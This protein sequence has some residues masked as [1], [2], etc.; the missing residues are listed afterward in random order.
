[1]G[2]RGL[3]NNR[4]ARKGPASGAPTSAVER[5]SVEIDYFSESSLA[6]G[7]P[8]AMFSFSK[9]SS[10]T[11]CP[12]LVLRTYFGR[13]EGKV[14][15]ALER[16]KKLRGARFWRLAHV[17]GLDVEQRSL[18]N[19]REAVGEDGSPASASADTS[20]RL[21]QPARSRSQC[22]G[23]DLLCA[24]YGLSVERPRRDRDLL[25]RLGIQAF[26]RMARRRGVS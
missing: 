17:H 22:H 12:G 3:A 19:S 5:R 7:R 20:A 4:Q 18:E 9:L 23:R 21:P 2:P 13:R 11:G 10:G 15:S 24:S 26:P 1:M 25:V 14:D 8:P 16:V 6:T